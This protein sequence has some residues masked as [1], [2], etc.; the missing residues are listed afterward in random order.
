MLR[1]DM[2]RVPSV[3]RCSIGVLTFVLLAPAQSLY[4]PVHWFIGASSDSIESKELAGIMKAACDGKAAGTTCNACPQDNGS[5]N[6]Q[7]SLRNVRSGHFLSRESHDV[8]LTTDGCEL[9]AANGS[10]GMLLSRGRRGWE[11]LDYSIAVETGHCRKMQLADAR[12]FLV[13]ESVSTSRD[14]FEH[15]IYTVSAAG[16]SI[17]VKRVFTA[18]DTT[19]SCYA[20]QAAQRAT[21]ESVEFRDLNGDGRD[22][23]SVTALYGTMKMTERQTAQCE[24]AWKNSGDAPGMVRPAL[25]QPAMLKR[26]RID[27]LFNGSGFTPAPASQAAAKFFVWSR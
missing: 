10:G 19:C 12:E 3:S 26:Y 24:D 4:P 11:K 21:I 6:G 18:G 20:G 1:R 9:P 23:L 17:E 2:L 22:D 25:P 16:K 27:L 15:S 13:C 7:W 8:L 14:F 5:A